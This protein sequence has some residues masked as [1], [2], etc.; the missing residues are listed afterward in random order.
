MPRNQEERVLTQVQ[1][2]LNQFSE[3]GLVAGFVYTTQQG[4]LKVLGSDAVVDLVSKHQSEL[5]SH[6]AFQQQFAEENEV[7]DQVPVQVLI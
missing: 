4:L 1:K 3:W 5:E 7:P 2:V 6:P